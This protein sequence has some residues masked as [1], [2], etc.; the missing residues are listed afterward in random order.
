[1]D[2]VLARWGGR[3]GLGERTDLAALPVAI[4]VFSVIF[5][6]L[7]PLQNLVVRTAEE[8][9]DAFGLNAAREPYGAA[10]AAMRLSTYRKLRPGRVEEFIFYDHPSGY[11]RVHAAMTWLRENQAI[12]V[13][14][15]TDR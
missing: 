6:A 3:L 8:E 5:F 4:A 7:T 15:G 14:A 1:M 11:E 2:G 13:A 10:M 12:V 9:A